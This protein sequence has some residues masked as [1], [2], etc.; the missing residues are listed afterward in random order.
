[1]CISAGRGAWARRM[2]AP[3]GLLRFS[4]ADSRERLPPA[5]CGQL[6]QLVRGPHPEP[7]S[8]LMLEEQGARGP[9]QADTLG[10]RHPCPPTHSQHRHTHRHTPS[11]SPVR[12]RL[13]LPPVDLCWE[14]T[15][16][17]LPLLLHAARSPALPCAPLCLVSRLVR[18]LFASEAISPCFVYTT[19]L[20][21]FGFFVIVE[22]HR[23]FIHFVRFTP[24]PS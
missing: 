21:A 22:K 13:Q 3:S 2:G 20:V 18:N 17:P 14:K 12:A 16:P 6:A 24:N 5:L 11:T 10:S 19:A 4:T 9:G 8:G 1:M 23:F 7:P 15:P